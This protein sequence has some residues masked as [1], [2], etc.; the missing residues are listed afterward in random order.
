MEIESEKQ[1]AVPNLKSQLSRVS[2]DKPQLGLTLGVSSIPADKGLRSLN[3][4][5][6]RQSGWKV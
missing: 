4:L 6:R 1:P 3:S 5:P 2:E